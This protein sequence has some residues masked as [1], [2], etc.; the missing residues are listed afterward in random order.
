MFVISSQHGNL[1][2]YTDHILI[3]GVNHTEGAYLKIPMFTL[4]LLHV[5]MI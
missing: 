2:M 5:T 3:L 4:K 1:V